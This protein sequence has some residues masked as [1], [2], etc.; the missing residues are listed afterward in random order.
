MKKTLL[1]FLSVCIALGAMAQGKAGHKVVQTSVKP[2]EVVVNKD[3]I[4]HPSKVVWTVRGWMA[5]E[6]YG[7]P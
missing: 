6:G 4:E 2:A 7:S 5:T 1:T 3:R